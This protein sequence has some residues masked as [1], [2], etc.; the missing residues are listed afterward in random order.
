MPWLQPSAA[1]AAAAGKWAVS[2]ADAARH[3]SAVFNSKH[4]ATLRALP[5][6]AQLLVCAARALAEREAKRAAIAADAAANRHSFVAPSEA[7]DAPGTDARAAAGSGRRGR[8]ARTAAAAAADAAVEVPSAVTPVSLL[9]LQEALAAFCAR[10]GMSAPSKMDFG[11]WMDRLLSDGIFALHTGGANSA[12]GGSA[13]SATGGK[14]STSDATKGRRRTPGANVALAAAW[15]TTYIRVNVVISELDAAL[16]TTPF[17]A[18]IAADV[19][20]GRI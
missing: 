5:P 17:Y 15:V 18:T 12:G 13:S 8:S 3:A 4:L 2:L 11:D 16:S 6:H 19:H 20:A 7:S 14:A 9:A 1:A 10:V